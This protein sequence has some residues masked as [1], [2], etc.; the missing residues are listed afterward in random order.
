MIRQFFLG[1]FSLSL[2]TSVSFAEEIGVLNIANN[3]NTPISLQGNTEQCVSQTQPH[4][5]NTLTKNDFDTLCKGEHCIVSIY[6]T[7]Y[8]NSSVE[9]FIDFNRIYG[10]GYVRA[11]YPIYINVE[12]YQNNLF[13]SN[14]KN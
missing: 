2:C 11:N 5:I 8:C 1:I 14:K 7:Y 4:T 10:I 9:Y 12:A 13:I 6:P 3:S